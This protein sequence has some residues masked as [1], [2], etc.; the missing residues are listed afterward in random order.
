MNGPDR[1]A[2]LNGIVQMLRSTRDSLTVTVIFA[3]GGACQFTVPEPADAPEL[4]PCLRD[5]IDLLTAAGRR[6]TGDEVRAGLQAAEKLHGD[7]T[8]GEWLSKGVKMGLLDNQKAADP[9][10]YGVL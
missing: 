8:V 2:I 10:G 9:P 3:H 1:D 6:M 4:S 5:I 7:R